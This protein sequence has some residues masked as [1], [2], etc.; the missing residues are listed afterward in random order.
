M[1]LYTLKLQDDCWY[2]GTTENPPRRLKEHRDGNGAEWTREHIPIGFSTKYPLRRIED[3]DHVCRLEEDKHV[4]L[5]MLEMGIN[6]VRGGSYTRKV[7]TRSDVKSLSK[8]IFH[9]TGGCL[10]CGRLS[11]WASDCY[12]SIDVVGNDIVDDDQRPRVSSRKR[13]YDA[14]RDNVEVLE[15]EDSDDD[16]DDEEDNH[17][18]DSCVYVGSWNRRHPASSLI[19]PCNTLHNSIFGDGED[20]D[21]D[22]DG[23]DDDDIADSTAT[24]RCFRCGRTG[25]WAN[26]CYARFSLDGRQLS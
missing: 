3:K 23:D 18:A 15:V 16:S 24:N 5:I 10:R 19:Q 4:K 6:T 2:V 14:L 21:D 1:F 8:E 22:D 17:N 11:H 20:D 26:S 13:P 25:H 12:A 7:L 9:A